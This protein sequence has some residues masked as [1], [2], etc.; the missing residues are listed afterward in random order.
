MCMFHIALAMVYTIS[1]DIKDTIVYVGTL[2]VALRC[3][4]IIGFN[5][6]IRVKIQ[7]IHP[8][9]AQNLSLISHYEFISG[10]YLPQFPRSL[11]KI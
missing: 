5:V 8:N 2:A 10:H 11:P 7:P 6:L 1:N 9:I 4:L 3:S